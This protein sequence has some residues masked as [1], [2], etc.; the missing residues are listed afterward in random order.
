M[1]MPVKLSHFTLLTDLAAAAKASWI[2]GDD[3]A[4]WRELQELHD[5]TQQTTLNLLARLKAQA[6]ADDIAAMADSGYTEEAARYEW[7]I[8]RLEPRRAKERA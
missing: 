3:E 4:A 6:P 2:A 1:T 7:A 8:R 5:A